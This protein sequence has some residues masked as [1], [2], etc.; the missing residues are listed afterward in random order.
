MTRSETPVPEPNRLFFALA[1]PPQVRSRAA[2]VAETLRRE[3]RL[4][5]RLLKPERYHLTLHFL[6]D[7]VSAD[8][9]R[10]ALKAAGTVAAPP[11]TL[12]LD[13]AGSF[14]NP[15]IPVWLGAAETPIALAHLEQMLRNALVHLP[16]ERQPRFVPHLTVLREAARPLQPTAIEP[17]DWPVAEFVLIRSILHAYPAQY[18][19]LARY[20]LRGSP[21]PPHPH[22]G[23]L[24]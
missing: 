11:F 24:F 9:E 23:D 18:Q 14:R 6:G 13:R 20:P 22:Q 19:T 16:Q 4:G 21:L 15:K 3:H 17:I 12:R 2:A 10:A 8:T 5:G 7:F 1:P